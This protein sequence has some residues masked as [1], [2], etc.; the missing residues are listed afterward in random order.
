MKKT[1]RDEKE[2]RTRKGKALREALVL[3]EDAGLAEVAP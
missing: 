1:G 2:L 3:E